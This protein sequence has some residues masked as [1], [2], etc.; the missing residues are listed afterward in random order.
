MIILDYQ[1]FNLNFI[2]DG[3][4]LIIILFLFIIEKLIINVT[5]FIFIIVNIIDI[6]E[7]VNYQQE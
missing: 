2:K 7:M 5:K 4:I 1:I 3:I 6:N